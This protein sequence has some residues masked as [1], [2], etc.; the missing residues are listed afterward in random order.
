MNEIRLVELTNC[1]ERHLATHPPAAPGI[2][3]VEINQR[4]ARLVKEELG[5]RGYD[6]IVLTE[7]EAKA[8]GIA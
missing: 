4:E 7:D 3:L 2:W 1:A 8:E 6:V 5:R